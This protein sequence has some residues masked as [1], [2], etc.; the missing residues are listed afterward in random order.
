MLTL[1]PIPMIED[2]RKEIKRKDKKEK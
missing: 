1:T 2:E